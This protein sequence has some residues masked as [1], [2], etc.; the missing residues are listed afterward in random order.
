MK[1]YRVFAFLILTAALTAWAAVSRAAL[2]AVE[3]S[4]AQRLDK[5]V[6][7][8]PFLV[9]SPPLSVYL[10]GYGAVFTAEINLVPASIT[11]F[12]PS[13]TKE[14]IG[15]VRQKKLERLPLLKTAMREMLMSGAASLDTVPGDEKLVLGV[16][17]F[18]HPWEDTSGLP[19]QIVMQAQR[20]VLVELQTGIRDKSA[21]DTV[22]RTQ[23]Y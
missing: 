6:L 7:G 15:R 20:R 18:H 3:K 21:A 23:E 10:D 1:R 11:P 4:M 8:E 2:A 14:E 19:A 22:I 9:L 17:L 16:S 5:L 12:R 13:F